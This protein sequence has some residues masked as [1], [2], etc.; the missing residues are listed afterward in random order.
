MIVIC[1]EDRGSLSAAEK[2]YEDTMKLFC[3]ILIVAR[4]LNS[5]VLPAWPEDVLTNMIRLCRT[6]KVQGFSSEMEKFSSDRDLTYNLRQ[7]C[8][9][10]RLE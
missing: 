3:E 9:I 7:I 1:D 2:F 8:E 6:K 5:D 4:I 10:P